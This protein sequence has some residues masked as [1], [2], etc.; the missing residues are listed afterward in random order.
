M[1]WL[2]WAV[3]VLIAG[4]VLMVVALYLMTEYKDDVERRR[5]K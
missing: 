2:G 5:R 3:I 1:S 4:V